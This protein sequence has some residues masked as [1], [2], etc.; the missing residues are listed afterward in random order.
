[1]KKFLLLFLCIITAFQM[2]AQLVKWGNQVKLNQGIFYSGFTLQGKYLGN[3]NGSDLYTYYGY[4]AKFLK[5]VD[6]QAAFIVANGNTTKK[7]TD[8]TETEYELIDV[9]TV[10]DQVGITYMTGKKLEK[11]NIKMDFYTPGTLK[12]NKSNVLFSFNPIDKSYPFVKMIHS[13]N[14][15]Y[16][17]LVINGKHPETGKGTMI[18][19][20]YDK[21]FT[22]LWTS[23][24]DFNNEGYPEIGDIVVSDNGKIV[25]QFFVY[26]SEK[27]K[28][29][30]NFQ[31]VEMSGENTK[32]LSYQ[33]QNKKIEISDYQLGC[34][35]EDRYLM[36]F[37]EP[38]NVTGIKIDFVS[39]N[40]SEII[41]YKPYE[42]SWKIDKIVDLQNGKYTVAMQN[43][44]IREITTRQNNMTTTTYYYWNRSFLFIGID[45]GNDEI[46]YKKNL[47]RKFTVSQGIET[48][49]LPNV[50][51]PYYFAKDGELC[52]LYNTDKK[53]EDNVS[54]SKEEP[55]TVRFSMFKGRPDARL[56]TI[57]ENGNIKVKLLF[58]A[59]TEKGTFIPQFSHI[60]QDNNLVI[61]K[62]K[63]KNFTIG[64]YSL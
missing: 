30:N 57:S 41:S 14:N 21:N 6:A 15:Q 4:F 16:I 10:E 59:K 44:G 32:E 7:F 43:R 23:Y 62:V 51:V 8:L 12:R 31:F 42:G 56:A 45:G 1:M 40:T 24:Y 61:V 54:N 36:V 22:E 17:G 28:A 39:E 50:I 27:K 47:G 33:F 9:S 63:K 11:R 64:K 2:N 60:D 25:I 13:P 20:C 53:T 5:S 38:K 3:V 49:E 18:F 46:L 34:Y 37:T 19:K 55:F 58:N 26:S 35:G 52:V 29:L 48:Y